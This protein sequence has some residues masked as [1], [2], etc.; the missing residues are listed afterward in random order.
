VQVGLVNVATN[1]F[2]PVF[3]VFNAAL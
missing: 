2:L 3:V 1:G